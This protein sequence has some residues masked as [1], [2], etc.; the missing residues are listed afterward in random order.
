M[1]QTVGDEE[2]QGGEI[3]LQVLVERVHP[4]EEQSSKTHQDKSGHERTLAREGTP[5]P[6]TESVRADPHKLVS[7]DVGCNQV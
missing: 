2:T 4:G 1:I 7:A 5:S 3:L 6:G